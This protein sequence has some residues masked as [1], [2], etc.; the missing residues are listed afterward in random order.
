VGGFVGGDEALL[1]SLL[2]LPGGV[3][4]MSRSCVVGGDS[5]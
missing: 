5:S 1:L 3:L 4:A 2:L